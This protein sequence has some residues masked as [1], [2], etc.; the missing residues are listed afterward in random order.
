MLAIA[1][2]QGCQAYLEATPTGKPIYEALGFRQ[3]D[4]LDFDLGAMGKG[5]EGVYS[6]SIMIREP[7][8]SEQ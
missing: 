5:R 8:R 1:D 2:A 4:T 7:K 3:V 6:L